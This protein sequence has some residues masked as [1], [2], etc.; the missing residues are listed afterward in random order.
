MVKRTRFDGQMDDGGGG[1]KGPR[2]AD[3][4]FDLMWAPVTEKGFIGDVRA[5]T[6]SPHT[7]GAVPTSA[8]PLSE[9][10]GI[11]P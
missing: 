11:S 4:G 2:M 8:L 9:R 1:T 5:K 3:S 6:I 7:D 10:R